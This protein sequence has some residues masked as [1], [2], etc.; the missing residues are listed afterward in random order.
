MRLWERIQGP[1]Y[2]IFLED[3][4]RNEG[5]SIDP[6]IGHAPA[7]NEEYS[8][9]RVFAEARGKAAS[10]C[11]TSNDNVVECRCRR[12][13]YVSQFDPGIRKA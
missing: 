9:I 5:Y 6:R 8:D 3:V 13:R 12:A 11:T 10:C 7:F 4:G 1:G 2:G